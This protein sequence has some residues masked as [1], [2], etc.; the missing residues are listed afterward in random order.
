[1]FR[2][3][4]RLFETYVKMSYHSGHHYAYNNYAAAAND[5]WQRKMAFYFNEVLDVNNDGVVNNVDLEIFRSIFKQMKHLSGD[6]ELLNRFNNFLN[7]WFRAIM[8]ADK[9]HGD[10]DGSITLQVSVNITNV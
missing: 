9:T 1:M 5:F 8:Q 7:T 10:N 4:Q 6:Q 3:R 2:F